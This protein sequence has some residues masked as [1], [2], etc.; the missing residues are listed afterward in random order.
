M[1]NDQLI[2]KIKDFLVPGF[3][4]IFVSFLTLFV[5]IPK[6][7]E[8]MSFLSEGKK[9][10]EKINQLSQKLAGLQTLSEAELFDSAS[11]LL[12]ALPAEKDFGN[13]LRIIRK[14]ASES[15]LSLESFKSSP[16]VVSTASSSLEES[17]SM[18]LLITYTTSLSGLKNFLGLLDKSLPI[19]SVESLKLTS[20]VSTVSASM[21]IEGN[22]T[23]SS[24]A[25]PL[26]KSLGG[27]EKPLT[28]LSSQETDLIE[29]LRSYIRYQSEVAPAGSVVIG[30]ENPF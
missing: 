10:T 22:M 23:I 30:K 12:E 28:K 7:Q 19:I 20:P 1:K 26:P 16:G 4:L 27:I 15:N 11:L 18:K 5:L 13:I 25:K 24:L 2:A 6:F 29:E 9:Q 8:I 3:A 21:F 17:G 14:N